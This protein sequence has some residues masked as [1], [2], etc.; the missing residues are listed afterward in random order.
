M[1]GS[2]SWQV[3]G[4]GVGTLRGPQPHPA[5]QRVV[6]GLEEGGLDGMGMGGMGLDGRVRKGKG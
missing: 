3:R 4:W 1:A 6:M 5:G 2:D